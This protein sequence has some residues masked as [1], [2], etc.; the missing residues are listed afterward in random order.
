MMVQRL[1]RASTGRKCNRYELL[2]EEC[3]KIDEL[4]FHGNQHF[5]EAHRPI[6][7]SCK[8]KLNCRTL[9]EK[10][11]QGKLKYRDEKGNEH[12]DIES[13]WNK[14]SLPEITI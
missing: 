8:K 13:F 5:E 7:H 2:M 10:N 1:H 11:I 4:V 3:L 9:I 6:E 12:P 14:T